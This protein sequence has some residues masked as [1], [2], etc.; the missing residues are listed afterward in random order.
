[1]DFMA[2]DPM[3]YKSCDTVRGQWVRWSEYEM[4]DGIVIPA[5]GAELQTYDP[6]EEFRSNERMYRTVQQPYI[7]LLELHRK[8]KAVAP[9]PFPQ[10]DQVSGPRCEADQVILEWCNLHGLLGLV[11]VLCDNIQVCENAWHFRSGGHKWFTYRQEQTFIRRGTEIVIKDRFPQPAFP[12]AEAFPPHETEIDSLRFQKAPIDHDF[13]TGTTTAFCGAYKDESFPKGPLRN[14]RYYFMP[15]RFGAADGFVVPRPFTRVFWS[16]YGEPAAAIAGYAGQFGTSVDLLSQSVLQIDDPD[17]IG[18][19]LFFLSRLA[20]TVAPSWVW[21]HDKLEQQ[22]LSPGLL[23]SY[24]LM[25]LLDREA[26]RRALQCKTCM[27]YFVSDERRAR[28]CSLTCRNTAQSRRYRERL[29]K[30]RN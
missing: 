23:A 9:P 10:D 18:Y 24:A 29:Q 14:L 30:G 16:S 11:P 20:Q 28:Y 27:K 8:L 26:K 6:W 25:F 12:D 21:A 7:A 17:A 22:R 3:Q 13:E 4:L 5:K 19:Y 1:M 15:T 2:Y